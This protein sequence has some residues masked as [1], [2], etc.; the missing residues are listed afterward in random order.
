MFDI[1]QKPIKQS[2]QLSLEDRPFFIVPKS[3]FL[4]QTNIIMENPATDWRSPAYRQNMV[5]KM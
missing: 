5:E 2:L 4:I 3:F 1:Q